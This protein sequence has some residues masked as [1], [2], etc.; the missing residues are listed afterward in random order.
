M[1]SRSDCLPAL[2]TC[3]LLHQT[4]LGGVTT[5]KALQDFM[6]RD[7]RGWGGA[8]KL[9][10]ATGRVG[11]QGAVNRNVACVLVTRRA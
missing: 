9:L 7:M 5:V 4:G 8:Y 3:C 10:N 2:H 6:Y 1:Q 11:S